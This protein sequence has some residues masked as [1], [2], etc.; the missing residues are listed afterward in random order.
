M[1]K[2]ES[3]DTV[4]WATS[5]RGVIEVI[6]RKA[7]GGGYWLVNDGD[8]V[9]KAKLSDLT[10]IS[11]KPLP[12]VG[13]IT[14]LYCVDVTWLNGTKAEF[15]VGPDI[16]DAMDLRVE[17]AS[18]S[19]LSG[20]FSHTPYQEPYTGPDEPEDTEPPEGLSER[21]AQIWLNIKAESALRWEI[22]GNPALS[23]NVYSAHD[24]FSIYIRVLGVRGG[25][26]QYTDLPKPPPPRL[27]DLASDD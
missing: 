17:I 4:S 8:K 12:P 21:D 23:E 11:K 18:L 10:L 5:P 6:A 15:E 1:S 25:N 16:R 20:S 2:I 9:E 3:G 13:D 14:A 7:H 24:V 19:C 26:Y 27:S 22:H